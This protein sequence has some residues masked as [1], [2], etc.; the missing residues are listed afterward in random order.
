[1]TGLY[2]IFVISILVDVAVAYVSLGIAFAELKEIYMPMMK[3]IYESMG[4]DH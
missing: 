4:W 3:K 2:I 1:M